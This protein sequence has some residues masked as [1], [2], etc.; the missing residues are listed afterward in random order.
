VNFIL[1]A[2]L[3]AQT[4]ASVPED[5]IDSPEAYFATSM[6]RRE[7]LALERP[8]DRARFIERYWLKRDPT[9]GTSRNEFR[10]VILERIKK[11][12]QK[13]AVGSTPG[14]RTGQ[15]RVFVIF[16]PPS[17]MRNAYV[18]PTD[19]RATPSA[20][21]AE[22]SVTFVYDR[23]RTPKLLE[24]VGLPSLT[25]DVLVKPQLNIDEIQA[26][27]IVEGLREKLARRSIVN[28]LTESAPTEI[29]TAATDARLPETIVQS[30][31][32]AGPV[33]LGAANGVFG[34]ATYWRDDSVTALV[35]FASTGKREINGGRFYGR[36]RNDE[37]KTI[38]TFAEPPEE[39]REFSLSARGRVYAQRLALPPGDFNAA[40]A[41]AD[42][43]G[44]VIAA[45]Q[46]PLHVA[47][48]AAP[49]PTSS[50]LVSSAPVRATRGL[51][52]FD[53]VSLLPR[54][55]ATFARGE[56]LWF[57]G[58]IHAAD[59]KRVSIEARVRSGSKSIGNTAVTLDATPVAPHRFL[60]GRE[61][62]LAT[63]EPGDYTL[64]V[65]VRDGG[66]SAVQ[67]ADFR[68]IP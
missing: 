26:P 3:L 22:T 42:H 13:F 18:R 51:F 58:E 19:V 57:F 32:E 9:P 7:W 41:V 56:S 31:D 37:G 59:P 2:L 43:D 25:I 36:I 30:L 54:A 49:L 45:A 46:I 1:V 55:D 60:F 10:E 61:L 67:R 66:G 17:R 29:P 64:Y 4:G 15:G 16:G 68:V 6:E 23:E 65:I 35:W 62:P 48:D 44:S 24:M 14:S 27:G 21:L 47:N 5:W 8:E 63:F 12:D 34:T 11:A 50:L 33:S 38:A 52:T 53:N 28:T 20:E 40:L 39:S